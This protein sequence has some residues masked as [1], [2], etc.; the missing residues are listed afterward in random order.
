MPCG[1]A[2]GRAAFVA[3]KP[4]PSSLTDKVTLVSATAAETVTV[5]APWTSALS[6]T[7][8][9]AWRSRTGFPRAG[10]R[11][12]STWMRNGR[13]AAASGPCQAAR[14]SSTTPAMSTSA[15]DDWSER[16]TQSSSS[17]AFEAV[18]G[19]DRLAQHSGRILTRE[20][21]F[22]LE[23]GAQPGERGAE[24]V[25]GVRAEGALALQQR[26]EPVRRR[27]DGPRGGV[28]L[29][30]PDRCHLDVEGAVAQRDDRIGEVTNRPREAAGDDGDQCAD[31]EAGDCERGEKAEHAPRARVARRRRLL[32]PDRTDHAFVGRD[33]DGDDAHTA[34]LG[35]A[36]PVR[37]RGSG[38]GIGA[39]RA[40]SRDAGTVGSVERERGSV[41]S[42]GQLHGI[43]AGGEVSGDLV[44]REDRLPLQAQGGV[45]DQTD[46]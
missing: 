32:G 14:R 34:G 23:G 22:G 13:P 31:R 3:E 20:L 9:R 6:S 24:L 44:G 40:P 11:S 12:S 38:V 43:V 2:G 1:S 10:G 46:Q 28:D 16:A 25:R 33:R 4:G 42:R 19:L 5:P 26:V 45:R 41:G 35:V 15:S 18:D 36:H 30:D 39:R 29:A 37:E 21:E 7:T 17:M 27:G 8:S